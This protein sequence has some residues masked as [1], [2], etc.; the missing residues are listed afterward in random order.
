M[1]VIDFFL[2]KAELHLHLEGSITPATIMELD[3][4]ITRQEAL[5][6]YSYTDFLGFQIGRAHV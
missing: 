1:S 2:D 5:E 3:P 4:A 6:L